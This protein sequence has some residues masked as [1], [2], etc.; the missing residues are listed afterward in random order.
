MAVFTNFAATLARQPSAA[1]LAPRLKYLN[2]Q[3]VLFRFWPM[4]QFSF[5]ID[6]A[7]MHGH[8]SVIKALAALSDRHGWSPVQ[9]KDNNGW[10]PI[11]WAANNGHTEA[12]IALTALTDQPNAA[13]CNGWTP[14]HWAARKGHTEVVRSLALLTESPNSADHNQWTPIHWAAMKGH[15]GPQI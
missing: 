8:T 2:F 5:L 12:V 6:W 11:H 4:Y 7:G 9:W 13:D 1:S 10:T 15:T 3:K 14:I